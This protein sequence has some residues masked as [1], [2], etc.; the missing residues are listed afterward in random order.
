MAA[1]A[2]SP[3]SVSGRDIARKSDVRPPHKYENNARANQQALAL[4]SCN[5]LKLAQARP[6]RVSNQPVE[7]QRF[8]AIRGNTRQK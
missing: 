1:E 4:N 6:S 3:S 7:C 8:V 5:P 2:D